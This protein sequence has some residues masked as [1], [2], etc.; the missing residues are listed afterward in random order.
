MS[1]IHLNKIILLIIEICFDTEGLIV[2]TFQTE[3]MTGLHGKCAIVGVGETKVGRVP[4]VTAMSHALQAAR[5][6]I[7]D[8]GLSNTD[9]DG[10]LTRKPFLDPTLCYSLQIAENLGIRPRYTTDLD[11][12]GTTP[13]TMVITSVM[14]IFAGLCRTV[15]CTFSRDDNWVLKQRVPKH[16]KL[17]WGSE[18]FEYPW[19]FIEAPMAFAMAARRHMHLYGTT[20][21]HF[22][23]IAIAMRKYASMNPNAQMRK[24]ITLQDYLASP[25]FA[26][27]FRLLDCSLVSDGGGAVVV[28]SAEMAKHLRKAPI[29]IL[30]LGQHNSAHSYFGPLEVITP[31][32]EAGNEA[33]RM[34][35]MSHRDID[36]AEVYDCFTYSVL[37]QLEDLGFCKKGEGGPFVEGGRIE[38]G[39]ELPVNTHGG[40]L[41]QAHLS[42]MLHITEAAH[43][44]WGESGE[45]QVKNAK[46]ALVT[47]LGIR[48]APFGTTGVLILGKEAS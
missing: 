25:L 43:Q 18:D 3:T 2:L 38:L 26:E 27:P 22:G 1:P 7:E 12:C 29:Y 36:V 34:A 44:L 23:A 6:A 42:G 41:S 35:G 46:V 31:L 37:V 14:A 10:V 24:P 13:I 5:R 9:I 16:G 47:G 39:G 30:G 17:N 15:L 48:Q 28:T 8:A 40:L 4:R 45:R 21:E 33:Y 11:T 20:S 19:G 32:R